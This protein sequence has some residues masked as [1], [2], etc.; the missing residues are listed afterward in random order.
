MCASC[1]VREACVIIVIS[2][3]DP[4]GAYCGEGSIIYSLCPPGTYSNL[5]YQ[6]DLDNCTI[7]PPGYF[8]SD[9]GAIQPS[10]QCAAGHICYLEALYATPVYNNESTDGKTNEGS[11]GQGIM[12]DSWL[13]GLSNSVKCRILCMPYILRT[14]IFT[15]LD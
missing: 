7:C 15:I 8:C 6:T 13:Y 1:H 2:L 3:C 10:G 11:V 4:P 5:T 9:R 12:Y 14:D